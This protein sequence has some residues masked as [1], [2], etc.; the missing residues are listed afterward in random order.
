[1]KLKF[2]ANQPYQ[3]DAIQSVIGLFEGQPKSDGAFEYTLREENSLNLIAGVANKSLLDEQQIL[4]N[5]QHLLILFIRN[6][7]ALQLISIKI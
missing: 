2:D 7:R 5:M 1:M 4:K 6:G 3:Q